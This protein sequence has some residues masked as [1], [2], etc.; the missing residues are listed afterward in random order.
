[1]AIKVIASDN[2]FCC[3]SDVMA[4][5]DW[6]INDRPDVDVVN[7]SLGSATLFTGTCD[8]ATSW[9]QA[10]ATAINTLRSDGVLTFASA[11]N[12]GSSTGISAP[13]CIANTIAVYDANI[14]PATFGGVCTDS[15]TQ[16]D[17]VACW[18][19]SNSTVD[20]FAPGAA[21]TS[22]GMGGGTSTFFGTSQASPTAAACAAALLEATPGLDPSV[23]ESALEASSILVTDSKNGVTR[24]RVACDEALA[25]LVELGGP[26]SGKKMLV[27]DKDG[28]DTKRKIMIL[29]KDEG[30]RAPFGGS[31]E[32]PTQHDATL[33]IWNPTDPNKMQAFTLPSSG[34]EGLGNPP[35]SK[36]YKY[37]D[38]T[39]A[40]GPCKVV[41]LKPGKLL[42]A[43]CMNR[44]SP[45]NP[46]TFD[47]ADSPQGALA[48][49][50]S[51]GPDDAAYCMEFGATTGAP[52]I[53]DTPAEDGGVGLFKAKDSGPP[54]DCTL[55]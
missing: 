47:L 17:Q 4:A 7:M 44:L 34:W 19:N 29:S 33:S 9:T 31:A 21:M 3:I 54:T 26:I 36:G 46:I 35:G 2:S 52:P 55:P 23:I 27:K 14:G 28:D 22:A 41:L 43:V 11:G 39:F 38:K 37:L 8:S 18:S 40:N 24:P 42:K 51:V 30:I 16:A 6:I 12:S 25:L 5:L 45:P 1:V 53:K 13:A 49:S 50:L 20:L 10:L 48:G 32:D 15:T